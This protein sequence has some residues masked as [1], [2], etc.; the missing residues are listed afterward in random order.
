MINIY[1]W[2]ES[3]SI[4]QAPIIK[5]ISN[6]NRYNVCAVIENDIGKKRKSMGWEMPDFGNAK[7]V[8]MPNRKER[9]ELI[10]T[11][12]P[13]SV[14]LFSGIDAYPE[15]YYTLK[16]L[17]ERDDIKKIP[18]LEP[19][20]HDQRFKSFMRL[21][22]HKY[23]AHKWRDKV[24]KVLATGN[25]G[26][27]WWRKAGFYGQQIYEWGYFVNSQLDEIGESDS[28]SNEFNIIIVGSLT[29]RKNHQ[30]L[31]NALSNLSN[32]SLRII[33]DGPQRVRLKNLCS[34]LD[35][36]H[37]VTFSGVLPNNKVIKKIVSA[38][39]LVLPSLFD[40]WGAVVNE[41]LSVGTPVICSD[42]CGSSSLIDDFWK[43]SVF[44]SN[45]VDDL[46]R[47]LN[48]RISS[49]KISLQERKSLKQWAKNSISPEAATEYFLRIINPLYKNKSKRNITVPWRN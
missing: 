36:S 35:I 7:M 2:L 22:K 6:E 25:L 38:D 10:Q 8:A 41:A 48:E 5:K 42:A 45:K 27:E 26:V 23:L 20:R 30:L 47:V 3:P 49:G 4:H 33:G 15:T 39:V 18:M 28:I 40:G 9:E 21:L 43:G 1:F 31:L 29:K 37:K 17:S 46:K 32:Y 11:V 13:G 34:N 14:H 24:D 19:G 12:E 44:K 16:S